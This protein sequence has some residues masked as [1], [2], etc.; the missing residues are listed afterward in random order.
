MGVHGVNST[1]ASKLGPPYIFKFHACKSFETPATDNLNKYCKG[2]EDGS[3]STLAKAV[4][5]FMNKNLTQYKK[6]EMSFSAI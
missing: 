4:K 2:N 6:R 3:K 5:P 1:T